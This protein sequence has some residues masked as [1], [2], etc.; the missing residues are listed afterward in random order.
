LLAILAKL[1]A[2]LVKGASDGNI[3]ARTAMSDI[4]QRKENTEETSA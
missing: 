2:M 1:I 3:S 4:M